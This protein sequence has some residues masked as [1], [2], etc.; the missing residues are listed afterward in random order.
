MPFILV[1]IRSATSLRKR[2]SDREGIIVVVIG[3][4]PVAIEATMEPILLDPS[5]TE[6]KYPLSNFC[7]DKEKL[8][9]SKFTN[10]WKN[11]FG[12]FNKL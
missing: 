2:D 5:A 6:I 12:E 4:G 8:R 3:V 1:L 10:F 9:P 7:I 11:P